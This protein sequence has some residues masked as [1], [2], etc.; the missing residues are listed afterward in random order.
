M[1]GMS[2]FNQSVFQVFGQEN[3]AS[4]LRLKDDLLHSSNYDPDMRPNK[5][6]DNPVKVEMGLNLIH[7]VE[8]VC[9]MNECLHADMH[10]SAVRLNLHLPKT[11]SS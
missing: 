11:P 3:P 7:L 5:D 8:V 9:G 2:Y 10:A 4:K 6:D 1:D